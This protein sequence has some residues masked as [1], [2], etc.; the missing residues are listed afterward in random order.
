M[1]NERKRLVLFW[2]SFYSLFGAWKILLCYG[3][4]WRQYVVHQCN[5]LTLQI[6]SV[7]HLLV[8][9]TS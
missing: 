6:S 9:A 1:K 3:S 5:F 8:S 2:V 7:S 4:G